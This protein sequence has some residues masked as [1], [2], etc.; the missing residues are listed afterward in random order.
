M[1]LNLIWEPKI[2][3]VSSQQVRGDMACFLKEQGVADWG[4][5]TEIPAEVL[6]EVAGRLCYNSYSKPRPGGN[7]AY[8]G[9][10]LRSGHGSVIEHS[11]WSFVFTGISRSLSHELVRSRVG[12][13]FS[14]L[15]QR[16]VDESDVSFVVPPALETEVKDAERLISRFG[17]P[18]PKS[19]DILDWGDR[20][21]GVGGIYQLT[22]SDRVGLRWMA[23]AEKALEDYSF[24]SDYLST[25]EKFPEIT[26]RTDRRK[27]AR[28]AARSVLPNSSE[29]K[30]FFTANGRALRNFLELR[31]SRHADAEIRRLAIRLLIEL[32]GESLNLFEDLRIVNTEDG[33]QEIMTEFRRV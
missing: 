24:L 28:E 6:V 14:Q 8:V 5:D 30:V 19:S 32:Q 3:L 10:I 7:S 21:H 31:G 25:P 13:S 9:N 29:T 23:A 11:V 17:E 33:R 18:F 4:T 26:N 2:H 20:H 16:Y 1:P 12:V 22:V 27:A 15:S